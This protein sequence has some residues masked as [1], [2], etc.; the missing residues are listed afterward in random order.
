[1]RTDPGG[2]ALTRR[3]PHTGRAL[4]LLAALGVLVFLCLLSIWLGSKEISFGA[5]W[6]VL[7][8]DDGSADAVII[9]SVRMPRTLLAV[10]VGAGARARRHA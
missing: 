7:W 8:H 10:L 3:P 2:I 1:M 9:H 6:Q 4:G 5:V